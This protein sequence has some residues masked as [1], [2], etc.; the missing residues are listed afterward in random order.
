[1]QLLVKVTLSVGII[2]LATAVAKRYPSLAGLIGVMPLTGALVLAWVF[3]ENNGDPEI[4]QR[5]AKGALGGFIPSVL[6]FIVAFFC[7]K[8]EIPLMAVL[9]VSFSAWFVAAVIHQWASK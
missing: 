8:R 3:L 4:M 9:A 7:L 2:L 5:F 1:M 6:F